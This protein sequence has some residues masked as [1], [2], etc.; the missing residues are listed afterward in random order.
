MARRQDTD[1]S[2]WRDSDDEADDLRDA[3]DP[4]AS[5]QDPDDGDELSEG[6][7][8]PYCGKLLYETADICP[9]CRSFVSFEDTSLRRPTWVRFGMV[10][11]VLVLLFFIAVLA[12]IF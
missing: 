7:P 6:E 11:L 9:H 8:C 4:D 10:L 3:E 2:D 12:W 1:D 5:D